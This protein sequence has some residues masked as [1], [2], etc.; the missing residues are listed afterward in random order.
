VILSQIVLI[1]VEDER[2]MTKKT[3]APNAHDFVGRNGCAVIY[4]GVFTDNKVRP[5]VADQLNWYNS[6]NKDRPLTDRYVAT[7]T[8]VH[9][10][11]Q[12]YR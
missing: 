5:S 3:V 10:P 8:D 12:A 11:S 4:E 7:A 2:V 1:I 9:L 6:A